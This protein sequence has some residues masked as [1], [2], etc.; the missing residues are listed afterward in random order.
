MIK[1]IYHFR[2]KPSKGWQAIQGP[3]LAAPSWS[4]FQGSLNIA[5]HH[6]NSAG[7]RNTTFSNVSYCER[8]GNSVSNSEHH[9]W[10]HRWQEDSENAEAEG[11][12][13]ALL[14]SHK[15]ELA[16]LLQAQPQRHYGGHKQNKIRKNSDTDVNV[17][18]LKK[19]K[20]TCPTNNWRTFFFLPLSTSKPHG[21]QNSQEGLHKPIP[22]I[23]RW[24]ICAKLRS[25]RLDYVRA[26][27]QAPKVLV[28][29][30]PAKTWLR[31]L[32]TNLQQG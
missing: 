24:E 19:K 20:K 16:S 17:H 7:H 10:K 22:Y 29:S 23:Q 25:Q 14:L 6:F 9:L 18:C 26:N 30:Y 32:D 21:S 5:A 11:R 15:G 1:A 31:T 12:K 27:I 13:P 4:Y 3:I 28:E 2:K 8:D